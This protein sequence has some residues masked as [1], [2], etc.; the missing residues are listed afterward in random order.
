[1][2]EA[3]WAKIYD[4][5]SRFISFLEKYILRLQICMNNSIFMQK[6]NAIKYLQNK[7]SN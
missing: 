4:F 6:M 3:A 7:S 2:L 5:Y 1:M